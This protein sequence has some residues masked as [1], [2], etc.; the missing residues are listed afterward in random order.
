MICQESSEISVLGIPASS[1]AQRMP[2]DSP[3]AQNSSLLLKNLQEPCGLVAE[4]S[5]SQVVYEKIPSL[6]LVGLKPGAIS[7]RKAARA[8]GVQLDQIPDQGLPV[9]EN[10]ERTPRGIPESNL[11]PKTVCKVEEQFTAISLSDTQGFHQDASGA[12]MIPSGY[13]V[14]E[15]HEAFD[16]LK[17]PLEIFTSMG[18]GMNDIE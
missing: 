13:G 8:N 3:K 14:P 15:A 1:V 18:M 16:L 9:I 17:I 5:R 11:D 12:K 2:M 4:F 6:R 10:K 7:L